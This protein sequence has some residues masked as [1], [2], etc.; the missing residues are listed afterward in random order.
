MSEKGKFIVFEGIGG[1]G[2]TIQFM[3]LVDNLKTRG[4]DV[5]ITREHTRDTPI[6]SLIERI[7]KKNETEEVDNVALQ[8]LFVADRINHTKRIILP[9]LENV[10]LK[11]GLLVCDRYRDSTTA[12][13]PPNK[14]EY[15]RDIQIPVT[16]RP[17]L[18]I[19]LDLDPQEAVRR[20]KSRGDEDIFDKVDKFIEVRQGYLW[21][22]ENSEGNYAWIDACGS[23]E[24]VHGRVLKA[25][26][27]II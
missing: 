11:R 13:A 8:M 6:G 18:T 21:C 4:I 20:V 17:D 12:Y 2:K 26:E 9:M 1:C 15:Y 16:L 24:E 10:G 22:K 25:V 27:E 3:K 14:R 5:G 23:V 19:L 7:I